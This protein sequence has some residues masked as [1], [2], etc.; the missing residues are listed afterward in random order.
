MLPTAEHPGKGK[1]VKKI[2]PSRGWGGGRT[3]HGGL[4]GQCKMHASVV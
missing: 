2:V 1:A 4:S 3:K